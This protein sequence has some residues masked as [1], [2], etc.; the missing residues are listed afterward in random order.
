MNYPP[1]KVDAATK[2]KELKVLKRFCT[3]E[4]NR[5]GFVHLSIDRATNTLEFRGI[6]Q[7]GHTFYRLDEAMRFI[8]DALQDG[9]N[10]YI[11]V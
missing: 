3:K 9:Y 2:Q 8:R 5:D 6:F 10:P 7:G 4:L 1:R 11:T